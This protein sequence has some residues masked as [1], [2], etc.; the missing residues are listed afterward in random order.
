MKGENQLHIVILWPLNVDHGMFV[1]TTY[2]HHHHQNQNK[3]KLFAVLLE[4]LTTEQ[5]FS[6]G[7]FWLLPTCSPSAHS[8]THQFPVRFP[9]H[10]CKTVSLFRFEMQSLKSQLTPHIC[11]ALESSAVASCVLIWH[12]AVECTVDESPIHYLCMR[13]V[14]WYSWK[15]SV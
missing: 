4:Y 15:A 12:T 7:K 9:C 6:A 10:M 11:H 5:W 14:A 1:T 8:L 2:C 13:P 3:P